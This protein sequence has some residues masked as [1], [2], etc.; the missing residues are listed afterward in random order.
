MAAFR[1]GFPYTVYAGSTDVLY[2]NR[3]DIVAPAAAGAPVAGGK[4]LLAREAFR[5]RADNVGTSGRNAFRGPGLANLDLSLSR[6]LAVPWLGDSSR[7]IF[8]ADAYNVLNHANL[9]AP[10]SFLNSPDFGVALYGRRGRDTGF[11][12]LAPFVENARQIELMLRFQF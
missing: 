7:L 1:S 4:R 10:D 11:P 5:E 12:A 3:A 9:N 2:N 6:E 8:R